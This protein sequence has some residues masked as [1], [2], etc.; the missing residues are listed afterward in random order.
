MRTALLVC[1]ILAASCI[2]ASAAAIPTPVVD[3]QAGANSDRFAVFAGG[4]F[5]GIE[6]VF[7]HVK[8]VKKVTSGYSGGTA[9]T[10]HYDIVSSGK[11]GHAE[12]VQIVYDPTQ[13]SYGRLLQILFAVGHD[14]TQ[15]NHQGPDYG[16]QYRSAVFVAS[17]EQKKIA[18]AYIDQLNK[19]RAFGKP[20]VTEVTELDVFYPAETYHQDYAA[21]HPNDLYIVINDAPK[22]DRLRQQFPQLY[23]QR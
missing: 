9:A 18:Q 22:V 19:A 14:P 5:W 4:C 17:A 20:I 10:A 23:R 15:L 6:A 21:H 13:I 8:G 12:A 7:E 11:T 2:K 3:E 1:L 16:P